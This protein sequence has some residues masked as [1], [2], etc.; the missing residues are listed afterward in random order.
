MKAPRLNKLILPELTQEE[1]LL[2]IDKTPHLRD[3]AILALFTES[4]L[5]LSELTNIRTCDIDWQNHTIKTLGK[6]NKEG[7]APFGELSRKYLNEWLS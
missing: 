5:R 3:K 7:Y 2:L 1:V 4:G 6:G